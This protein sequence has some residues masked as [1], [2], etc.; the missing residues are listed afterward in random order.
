MYFQQDVK[1][2]VLE[3]MKAVGKEAGL[4]SFEQVSNLG[5]QLQFSRDRHTNTDCY[6]GFVSFLSPLRWRT[7]TCTQR[8]SVLPTASSHQPWR[9]DAPTSAESFRNRYQACTA[10][11]PFKRLYSVIYTQHTRVT[12]VQWGKKAWTEKTRGNL[13][14]EK[15]WINVQQCLGYILEYWY[16]ASKKF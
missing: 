4:K 8:R 12:G 15:K 6:R 7:F 2:A 5:W 1:K 14:W 11:Q 10:K 9:V 13:Q 3:D 16:F